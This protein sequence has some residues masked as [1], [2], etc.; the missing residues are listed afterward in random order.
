VVKEKKEKALAEHVTAIL[1]MSA[2]R[3]VHVEL[4]DQPPQEYETVGRWYHVQ[5]MNKRRMSR[6]TDTQ[7]YLLAVETQNAAGQPVRRPTGAIPFGVRHEVFVRPGRIIGPPVEWDFCNV[8]K[9]VPPRGGP[10]FSLR[11]VVAPTD[12]TTQM[13]E[14]F[15]MAFTLQARSIEKDSNLLRVE[16]SWNGQ[17]ADDTD[18]MANYL[19]INAQIIPTTSDIDRQDRSL[20]TNVPIRFL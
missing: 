10:I 20:T 1:K 8:A 18:Q 7:V 3:L 13:A 15:K 11:T 19:V 4:P 14:P 5:V 2:A 12:I 16:V 9:E 17:W 6:A